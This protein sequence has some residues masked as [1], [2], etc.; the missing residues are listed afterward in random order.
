MEKSEIFTKEIALI[1]DATLKR[2]T[3]YYLNNWTPDIFWT[4]G[5]SASGKFHPEFAKGDG[6]LVR[7]TK[8]VVMFCDELMRMSQ[9]AYMTDARKDIAIMACIFHDTCK[10]GMTNEVDTSEYK[11]HAE[12]AAINVELA[13]NEYFD[14][15]S[16][17]NVKC[18]Y[19]LTQ[20]IRSHMGQWSTNRDDRPF[21]PIDRLVHLADYVASRNFLSIPEL[22]D[23]GEDCPF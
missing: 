19:E 15:Y 3:H 6:G 17:P 9:W 21:T 8:A 22:E 10:Y 12:N 1:K 11:N 4:T 18:P 16:N 2:F 5:A 20:A 7:H 23:N 13:W 14:K